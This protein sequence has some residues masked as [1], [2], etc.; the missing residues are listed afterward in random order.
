M[1]SGTCDARKNST[2]HLSGEGRSFSTPHFYSNPG[3]GTCSWNIT[4]PKGEFIKLTFWSFTGSCDENYVEVFDVENSTSKFLGK[5]CFNDQVVYSK[6]SNVIVKFSLLSASDGNRG[7]AATYEALKVRPAQYSCFSDGYVTL[8][9]TRGDFASFGY[10]L[11]YPN[12]VKCSWSI[13]VPPEYIIQLTFHSFHLQ[14]SQDCEVDFV[15][16][17]QG[18]DAFWSSRIGKFCGSSLPRVILSNYSKVFVDFVT[19][20]FGRYP[21]F[22]A[23]YIAVLNRKGLRNL[24]PRAVACSKMAPLATLAEEAQS[25]K[26]Q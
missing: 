15:E 23:S 22:H 4:V 11:L 12:N 18:N 2:V 5:F 13:E 10:P 17:K 16:I 19:D 7:F 24:I 14:Q 6:G 26:T 20:S 9:D 25:W 21:G 1:S 3:I 8:T